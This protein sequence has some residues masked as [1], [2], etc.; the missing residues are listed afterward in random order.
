MK[1]FFSSGFT[2]M[3]GAVGSAARTFTVCLFC[4]CSLDLVQFLGCVNRCTMPVLSLSGKYYAVL[5][6]SP[7]VLLNLINIQARG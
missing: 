6:L 7:V 1:V 5:V 3:I 4:R 2:L